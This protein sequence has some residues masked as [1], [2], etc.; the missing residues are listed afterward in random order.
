MNRDLAAPSRLV[1][2]PFQCLGPTDRSGA[3]QGKYLP[4]VLAIELLLVHVGRRVLASTY[5][6]TETVPAGTLTAGPLTHLYCASPA[7]GGGVAVWAWVAVVMMSGT[8]A[9]TARTIIAQYHQRE[10]S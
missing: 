10:P 7:S 2:W 6:R 1:Y 8:P 5:G 3:S 9:R 4:A